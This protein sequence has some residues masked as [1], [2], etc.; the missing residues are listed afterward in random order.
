MG[1]N[2]EVQ[3][4]KATRVVDT[5][6]MVDTVDEYIKDVESFMHIFFREPRGYRPRPNKY[7]YNSASGTNGFNVNGFNR[8][9]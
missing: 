3:Q 7:N 6:T 9:A 4:V 5:N 2:N 8:K 1:S